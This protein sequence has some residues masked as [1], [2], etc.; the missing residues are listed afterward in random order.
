MSNENDVLLLLIFLSFGLL[1][2]ILFQQL[3]KQKLKQ[4]ILKLENGLKEELSKSKNAPHK[5]VQHTPEHTPDA[6]YYIKQ[7]E[8]LE[9]ELRLQ[10][11][12]VLETKAIAQEA[13]RVKSEFLSN[14][15]HEIRTPMN[16][17]MVFT[18]LL[19]QETMDSKLKSYTK[20]ISVSGQKLLSLLDDIIELSSVESGIFD[21]EE[22]PVDIRALV[23]SVMKKEEPKALKKGLE[24]S[25]SIGENIPDTLLLDKEK[26]EEILTNL[27]ENAVKF[28]DKGFVKLELDIDEKNILRNAVNIRFLVKDSGVGI[29]EQYIDRIFEIFEKPDSDD[30]KIRGAGLGLSINKKLAKAMNGDIRVVSKPNEGSVFT[31]VLRNVEVALANA[32]TKEFDEQMIDFS[33]IKAQHNKLLVIDK[34]DASCH[35]IT[36]AFLYTSIDVVC[37]GDPRNA[38]NFLQQEP[39]DAIF[40]D[41]NILTDD[42]NAVAKILMKISSAAVVTITSHRLK[43]VDFADGLKIAGHLMRPISIAEL[44]KMTLEAINF[45]DKQ[46]HRQKAIQ[47]NEDSFTPINEEDKK[48]FLSFADK[49]LEPLYQE[50]Y[51]TND[52]EA[53]EKFAKL[54]HKSAN[55]YNMNDLENFAQTLLQ[56]IELFD[57]DAIHTMM[58]AYKEKIDSLKNL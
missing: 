5:K 7:I 31:F 36:E 14:I 41:V 54:L 13:N 3:S 25:A 1:I 16:S 51:K 21:I 58:Q 9:S 45:H 50:A 49:E 35:T 37:F 26:V 55:E 29:E 11:K 53:I 42:D 33:V 47:D 38:I 22:T 48:A 46:S 24:I 8:S 56:K 57:I 40:I 52:L 19:A 39:V 6:L 27:V 43:D 18:D 15:R 23:D 2:F 32:D 17:I 20:N 30:E 12:R 34:D 10:K 28:T 44:F 4:K